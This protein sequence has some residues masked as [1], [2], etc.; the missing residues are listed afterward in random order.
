MW[1]PT[2][3]NKMFIQ[4]NSFICVINFVNDKQNYLVVFA[5]NGDLQKAYKG[6]VI[7]TRLSSYATK[8]I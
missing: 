2:F 7:E 4:Q 8:S 5:K 3:S 1:S 6:K